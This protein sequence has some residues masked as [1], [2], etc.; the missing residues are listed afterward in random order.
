MRPEPAEGDLGRLCDELRLLL[1]DAGLSQA[2]AVR[3]V[4]KLVENEQWPPTAKF[5]KSWLSDILQGRVVRTPSFDVVRGLVRVCVDTRRISGERATEKHWQH[6]HAQAVAAENSQP[7][8]AVPELPRVL[9]PDRAGLDVQ[10][11]TPVPRT[12]LLDAALR[13]RDAQSAGGAGAD[14]RPVVLALTGDG[15]IGKSVLLGQLLQRLEAGKG[16]VALLSCAQLPYDALRQ[17]FESADQAI[18]EAVRPGDGKGITDLLARLRAAYGEVTLLVDTLDLV[19][20]AR[21]LPGLSA[22]LS[23]ALE[24]GQVVMTCRD[25]EYRDNLHYPSQ[26]APRLA[27]RLVEQA[28]PML[29]ET[30]IVGWARHHLLRGG[31]RSD[32]LTSSD[33]A[34]LGVLRGRVAVP[35]ALRRICA[36]PVRLTMACEVYAAEG[37][38][39]ENLTTTQLNTA[40][41]AARVRTGGGRPAPDKERAVYALAE[42]LLT[43]AGV[44]RVQVPKGELDKALAQ[45]QALEE[46]M[47]QAVSEGLV[48]DGETYWEFFHQSFGEYAY[49]RLLLRQGTQSAAVTGV[50]RALGSGHSNLWPLVTSLLSQ[51][52][53]Y[54]D[55]RDLAGRLPADTT[56]AARALVVTALGRTD[57][58][59]LPGVLER[60]GT[61][62]TLMCSVALDLADAPAQQLGAAHKALVEAVDSH[63]AELVGPAANAL[64]ELLTRTPEELLPSRLGEA[65]TAVCGARRHLDRAAR[66]TWENHPHRL[67]AAL[68]GV[69]DQRPEPDLDPDP[70]RRAVPDAVLTVVREHYPRLGNL[71]RRT[72]IV[73]HLHDPL[74]TDRTAEFARCV[75][76][77]ACPPALGHGDAVR[78]M[79]LFWECPAVREEQGWTGWRELLASKL[80]DT[81]D[82]AQVR[83]VARL[84]AMD[85]VVRAGVVSDILE[86]GGEMTRHVNVLGHLAAEHTEWLAEQLLTQDFGE[87]RSSAGLSSIASCLQHAL[88][89]TRL[90]VLQALDAV[91]ASAPRNVWPAQIMLAGDLVGE[92]LRILDDLEVAGPAPH[93]VHSMLKTWVNSG[94]TAVLAVVADRLRELMAGPGGAKGPNGKLLQTRARLE[95]RLVHLDDT[96]RTWLS[97]VVLEGESMTVAGTAVKTPQGLEDLPWGELTPWLCELLRS[98]HTDAVTRLTEILLDR[99]RVVDA[100]FA[101]HAVPLLGTA[102][103]RMR[104]AVAADEDPNLIGGLLKLIVRVDEHATLGRDEVREVYDITRSRLPG[105]AG[106]SALA[107][108][109]A[110]CAERER[111]RERSGWYSA[112]LQDVSTVCGALLGTRLG[113]SDIRELL[114]ELLPAITPQITSRTVRS[115]AASLLTGVGR[116]DAEGLDWLDGLFVRPDLAPGIKYA[117]AEAVLDIDG[118]RREGRAAGL[119]ALPGCP[120]DVADHIRNELRHCH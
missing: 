88:P 13:K 6:R 94:P 85:P 89:E 105:A 2:Q 50:L 31:A 20:D 70:V 79:R 41:W 60:V 30:E 23:Q 19:L 87:S 63:P 5:S 37:H 117:I 1:K 86:R 52:T 120:D 40:Y 80:P 115:R 21:T 7:A 104:R 99:S 15:G 68:P 78:V 62:P 45:D 12:A 84:G 73:A 57:E 47:A 76:T 100:V 101:E 10:Q 17:G 26:S 72:A 67:L 91:R 102:I 56:Q 55:Y 81:W 96:A 34:F 75:L 83:L 27:G 33:L 77:V 111:N 22:V 4:E 38:I 58:D 29:S 109:P 54:D 14:G 71:A 112:A 8:K 103:E 119:L 65:L 43:P 97:A 51:V 53:S 48:R 42:L 66:V 59:S 107:G 32:G 114:A 95:S 28:M 61:S 106:P 110:P 18:G 36:L 93:V 25:R 9:A 3:L 46:G 108:S 116:R 39:P 24:H 98:P 44:L 74:S 92:H 113:R 11:F 49:P 16:A 35:G 118:R 69:T 82:N 90:R 64:A